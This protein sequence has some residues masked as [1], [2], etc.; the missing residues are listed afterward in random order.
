MDRQTHWERVYEEKAATSVSWYRPHLE[1]SLEL[2]EQFAKSKGA[3]VLDIG[4]GASTLVD[5]LLG[6][7]FENVSV[8]DISGRA[9]EASRIRIGERAAKVPWIVADFLGALL[10]K[11]RYDICHDRAVFHFLND[12]GEKAAYFE[13]VERILR[14]EGVL[15]LAT[16]AMDGPERCSGLPVSRYDEAGLS[17]IVGGQFEIVASRRE[18]HHTPWGSVQEMMYFVLRRSV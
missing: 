2:I 18:S 15:I 10:E 4:G 17:K 11:E 7:G 3:A 14:P 13:Q 5:D 16:F 1:R 12:H 6:K 9:L 8:L